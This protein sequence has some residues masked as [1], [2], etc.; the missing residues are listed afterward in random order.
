MSTLVVTD[1]TC[2]I[3][4]DRVGELML[5]PRLFSVSAPPAVAAEFG[6][7]PEWL[8]VCD[9]PDAAHVRHLRRVLDLGEAEAIVLAL[10]LPGANLLVDE[11]R[12][13]AV[14][15]SLG[16]RVVGTAGVLLE[17]KRQGLLGA[18]RPVLDALREHH[19]FRLSTPLYDWI[20]REAGE[21]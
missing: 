20:I 13:R 12:G 8:R 10:S 5:L 1:T 4:L 11:A 18:V 16:L 6:R 14:A 15:Q 19:A 2:L 17:A 9:V 7:T 21:G 3:A